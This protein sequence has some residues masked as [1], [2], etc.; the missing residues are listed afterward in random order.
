[1]GKKYLDTKEGSLEQSIL[2][3]WQEAAGVKKEKLDPVGKEDGDIDNDGDKDASDKYLA[4]RRKT[5]KKAMSKK[6]GN[7]F[8]MAL[9]S[10][11]DNGEKT[12]V[13]SGKKYN[14]EDYDVKEDV[15]LD[16]NG[17]L[18]FKDIEKLGRSAASRI[19]NEARRTS[20][21]DKMS[22][23]Q[24][25]EL[26]YKIAKKLGMKVEEVE[27]KEGKMSQLHQLM[28]DGKSAEEIAKIMRVDAKT[29]KKLMA[30]YMSAGHKTEA[31]EF[32][33]DKLRKHTED[34]T[35]GQDGDWVDAQK[36]KNDS[37]RETLAKVWGFDEGKSPFKKESKKDL[38]KE[39]KDGK[40]MT[41]KKVASVEMNPKIM[42]KKK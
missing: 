8:G 4:K 7:A 20:G 42:E 21:Y 32:G 30:G 31:L 36:G 15:A 14:V 19:D 28:K 3:L 25:D 34:V 10:A 40:T 38:T 2:G 1:M 12:F 22:A 5:I 17:R 35:P 39:V 6:E 23:G 29:I 16:E 13:V 27:V 41:G 9:K 33:T 24:K 26:R 18:G 11:K 37:M